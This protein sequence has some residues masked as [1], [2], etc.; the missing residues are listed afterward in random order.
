M[1]TMLSR[2]GRSNPDGKLTQRF[3]IPVTEDLKERAIVAA[4]GKGQPTAEFLRDL[5]EDALLNGCWFPLTAEAQRALDVLA[6]LHDQTNGQ[7][8][9]DLVNAVLVDRF[10][11]ARM[12][13][14]KSASGQSDESRTTGTGAGE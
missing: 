8:L 7:Y 2:S 3:D 1:S 12:V 13:V 6:P 9:V 5:L 14:Q 4:A 11:M 10:C